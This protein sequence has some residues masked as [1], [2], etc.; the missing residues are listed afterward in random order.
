MKLFANYK[1]CKR[2]VING[3]DC[4]LIEEK[5]KQFMGKYIVPFVDV[6]NILMIV[7]TVNAIT[8]GAHFIDGVIYQG[9]LTDYEAILVRDEKKFIVGYVTDHYGYYCQRCKVRLIVKHTCDIS[10]QLF[11]QNYL[12]MPTCGIPIDLSLIHI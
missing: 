9:S 2:I 8:Q 4:G 10:R 5:S 6:L 3:E 7:G 1:N 11:V 12:K